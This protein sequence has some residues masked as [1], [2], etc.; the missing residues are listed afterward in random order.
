MSMLQ[1]LL[2]M[3]ILYLFFRQIYWL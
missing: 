3:S 2:T 1:S